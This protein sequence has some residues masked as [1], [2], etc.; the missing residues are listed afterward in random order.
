MASERTIV[1]IG[2]T[3]NGERRPASHKLEREKEKNEIINKEKKRK[4]RERRED[5]GTGG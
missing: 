2:A 5:K 1:G 4:E 3:G